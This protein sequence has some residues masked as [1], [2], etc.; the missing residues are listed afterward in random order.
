LQ[1]SYRRSAPLGLQLFM[2]NDT[3]A[4]RAADNTVNAKNLNDVTAAVDG[5][6]L[7]CSAARIICYSA[8]NYAE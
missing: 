6:Q 5:R 8:R 1:A 4:A 7:S 2:P 3:F